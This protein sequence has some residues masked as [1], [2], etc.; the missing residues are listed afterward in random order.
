MKGNWRCG[1]TAGSPT[2]FAGWED[3]C[4]TAL[5]QHEPRTVPA[6][7]SKLYWTLPLPAFHMTAGSGE[8]LTLLPVG[9]V[10]QQCP[11]PFGWPPLLLTAQPGSQLQWHNRLMSAGTELLFNDIYKKGSETTSSCCISALSLFLGQQG[12]TELCADLKVMRLYC[13]QPGRTV[14]LTSSGIRAKSLLFRHMK[15]LSHAVE[16]KTKRAWGAPCNHIQWKWSLNADCW[17]T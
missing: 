10:V 2:V 12:T 8:A 3:T 5:C 14:P 13:S 7:I 16:S 4:T 17:P 11:H 15:G 1:Y 9:W 6:D